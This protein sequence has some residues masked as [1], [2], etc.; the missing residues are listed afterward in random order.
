MWKRTRMKEQGG[1]SDEESEEKGAT[2]KE[3]EEGAQGGKSEKEGGR[4][5]EE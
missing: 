4:S 5:K 2:R 1:Q 3:V